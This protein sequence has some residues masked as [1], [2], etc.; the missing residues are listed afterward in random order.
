MADDE[1]R[2]QAPKFGWRHQFVEQDWSAVRRFIDH[3]FADPPRGHYL[4]EIIDSVLERGLSERLSIT[5]SMHD[6]IIVDSPPSPPPIDVLIVRAP[7]S[8]YP[9]ADGHVKIDYLAA[10]NRNTSVERPQQEAVRVFWR[11]VEEK[12][13]LRPTPSSPTS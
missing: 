7:N 1:Y 3:A 10:S 8:L 13:G 5:T 11:M 9:P 4:V 12:F 2:P 6:L